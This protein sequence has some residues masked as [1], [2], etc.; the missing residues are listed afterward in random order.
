MTILLGFVDQDGDVVLAADGKSS[1]G[2]GRSYEDAWKIARLAPNAAIGFSGLPYYGNQ[3]LANVMQLPDLA[4][5]TEN[6]RLVH[7]F[8]R[9][10]RLANPTTL[11][12]IVRTMDEKLAYLLARFDEESRKRDNVLKINVSFLGGVVDGSKSYIV[13]WGKETGWRGY[14]ATA[15]APVIFGPDG[16]ERL[17]DDVVAILRQHAVPVMDRV[18]R[19]IELYADDSEFAPKVNRNVIM[20]R[21]SNQFGLEC[22]YENGEECPT[23]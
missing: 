22:L 1:D 7:E 23:L 13:V 12:E 4:E 14:D 16:A 20:R 9:M 15:N 5:K 8:E 6:V 11:A 18:C 10:R 21:G 17:Y 19:A 2:A 3:I